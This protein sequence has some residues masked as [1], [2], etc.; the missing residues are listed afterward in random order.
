MFI[1]HLQRI[2]VLQSAVMLQGR[3]QCFYVGVPTNDIVLQRSLMIRCR[4]RRESARART[5]RT[6]FRARVR[7]RAGAG[8]SRP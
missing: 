5:V 3:E 8:T 1:T 6:A 4:I 7:S 2:V